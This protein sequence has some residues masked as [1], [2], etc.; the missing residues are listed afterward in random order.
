M[1]GPRRVLRVG[2]IGLGRWGK[3]L[4]RTLSEA[5]DVKLERISSRSPPPA[6]LANAGRRHFTDWRELLDPASIDGVFIATPPAVHAAMVKEAVARHIP[7]FV[8]KPLTMNLREAEEV[9]S[10]AKVNNA[11]VMVDHTHLFSAAYRELKK[12]AGHWGAVRALDC[13]AGNMGPFRP[14]APVLWDWGSHDMALCMDFLET[15]PRCLSARYLEQRGVDRAAGEVIELQMESGGAPVRM[16]LGNLIQPKTR[17]FAAYLEEALFVYDD[18]SEHKLKRYDAAPPF[19][20]PAGEGE[21]IATGGGTPLKNA[22]SEFC[23]AVRRGDTHHASIDL[24]VGVVA[25]LAECEAVLS[26]REQRP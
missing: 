19:S 11:L 8:E 5:P 14:D 26:Q 23:S 10:A 4:M 20:R 24:G 15:R 7:V 21:I 25:A 13:I 3:T 2:L 17:Y 22:I 1:T 9:K 6:E 18:Q 12:Q 16:Q